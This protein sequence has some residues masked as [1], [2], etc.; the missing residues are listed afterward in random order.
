M[1]SMMNQDGFRAHENEIIHYYVTW[2]S[3]HQWMFD[4]GIISGYNLL[5]QVIYTSVYRLKDVS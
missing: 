5:T 4:F 3:L 2:Q 1:L